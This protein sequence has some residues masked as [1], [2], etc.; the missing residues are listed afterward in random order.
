MKIVIENR[1]S[2]ADVSAINCVVDIMRD[3]MPF[4]RKYREV[5][6]RLEGTD[7]PVV[8]SVYPTSAEYPED[9][10]AFLVKDACKKKTKKAGLK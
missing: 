6:C 8:V 9:V 1:S 5:G 4:I 10:L 2:F 3:E 7:V